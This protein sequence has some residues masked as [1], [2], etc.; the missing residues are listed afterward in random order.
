MTSTNIQV[1]RLKQMLALEQRRLS[2]QNELDA[3]AQ[4]IGELSNGL[5]NAGSIVKSPTAASA[6]VR[7]A[8]GKR[9]KRGLL[10]EKITAALQSAG[11][12]GVKVKELAA[13]LGTKP[14]NIHSWFHSALKRD[15]TIKKI[16]GGHYRLATAATAPKATTETKAAKPAK[17][18][19]NGAKRG[20]LTEDILGALKAAG[21]KGITVADLSA[22]LG[23]KYKN[24]YIWFA[25]TGKK[26]PVKK[27]APATY[28]LN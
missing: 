20:Q 2:L 18:T 26:H 3:L 21:S 6:P 11:E 10:K 25:T 7:T 23:A 16:T 14:V 17:K 4:Q 19:R 8:K 22:K 28:K 27:L 5:F 1:D 24:I 12:L 9:G 15:K 13:Q